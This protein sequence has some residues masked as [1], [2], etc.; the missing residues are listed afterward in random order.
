MIKCV[1]L[2]CLTRWYVRGRAGF[3]K[4]FLPCVQVILPRIRTKFFSFCVEMFFVTLPTQPQ[5]SA[6]G[7]LGLFLRFPEFPKMPEPFPK[8]G[9]PSSGQNTTYFAIFPKVGGNFHMRIFMFPC[10]A[11]L[12]VMFDRLGVP[13]WRQCFFAR[14]V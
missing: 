9:F 6:L 11:Y 12:V 4:C 3:I 7:S 5:E 10:D 8:V 2:T 1:W 14:D 13:K